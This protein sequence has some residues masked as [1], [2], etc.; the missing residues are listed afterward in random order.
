MSESSAAG[1][2]VVAAAPAAPAAIARPSCEMMPLAADQM[3]VV[4]RKALKT[5]SV[6]RV[7]Y[8]IRPAR[9]VHAAVS[10]KRQVHRPTHEYI[11][12]NGTPRGAA[13]A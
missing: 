1:D 4:P 6:K 2:A 10:R 9:L 13:Q 5:S 7:Q 8:R 3:Y 11:G 12:R